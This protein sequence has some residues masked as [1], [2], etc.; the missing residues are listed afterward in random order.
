MFTSKKLGLKTAVWMFVLLFFMVGCGNFT[1]VARVRD[2]ATGNNI[3]RAKVS[4]EVTGSVPLERRTDNEGI[5]PLEIDAER[6]GQYGFVIVEA[7]G[8]K[9]YRRYFNL[10]RDQ[11]PTVFELERESSPDES[12]A[13]V[14]DED[15]NSNDAVI[16][17]SNT[18]TPTT[19]LVPTATNTPLATRTPLPPTSTATSTPTSMPTDTPTRTPMPSPTIELTAQVYYEVNLPTAQGVN[20]YTQ[21]SSVTGS[22]RAQVVG[23]DLLE[24]LNENDDGSWFYVRILKNN[25][26]GWIDVSVLKSIDGMPPPSPTPAPTSSTPAPPGCMAVNLERVPQESHSFDTIQL[27][28][29][30]W[31]EGTVRFSFEVYTVPQGG[32]RAYAVNPTFTDTGTPFYEITYDVFENRGFAP[33]TPFTYVFQPQNAAGET[34]CTKSGSFT[35]P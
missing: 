21:P 5:A 34:L 11:L 28:W 30:N 31:P 33:N 13:V 27:R 35:N 4:I 6:A 9:T 19:T 17:P 3:S 14:G 16:L 22:P 1:Y 24:R 12:V 25:I 10:E 8:Y 15:A 18:E 23:G 29:S 20:V 26:E 32:G 2:A 7:S